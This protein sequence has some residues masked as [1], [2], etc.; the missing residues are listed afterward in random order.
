[1]PETEYREFKGLPVEEQEVVLGQYRQARDRYQAILD[2]SYYGLEGRGLMAVVPGIE[3]MAGLTILLLRKNNLTDTPVI[4]LCSAL[5]SARTRLEGLDL[6]EN[7]ALTDKTAL[8][9][10]TYATRLHSLRKADFEEVEISLAVL[11]K[12]STVLKA[13][14]RTN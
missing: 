12:L 5:E 3:D 7:S 10:C 1:M 4:Y 14:Q 8:S 6:S 9:V 2:L 11:Q 13:N